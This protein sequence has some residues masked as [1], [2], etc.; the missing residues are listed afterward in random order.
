M[1]CWRRTSAMGSACGAWCTGW[2]MDGG[3]RWRGQAVF[4]GASLS[5]RQQPKIS[6]PAILAIHFMAKT[7]KS[8]CRAGPQKL[9]GGLDSP[10]DAGGLPGARGALH[11]EMGVVSL[12]RWFRAPIDGLV[13]I[14]THDYDGVLRRE[15]VPSLQ[16]FLGKW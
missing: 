9:P 3:N 6:L 4:V 16:I 8:Y 13:M 5:N 12:R 1:I 11:F 15:P 10:D 7:H 2:S 14:T